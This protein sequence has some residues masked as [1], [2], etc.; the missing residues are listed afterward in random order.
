MP[1]ATLHGR[2]LTR[3]VTRLLARPGERAWRIIPGTP[4][5]TAEPPAYDARPQG[6]QLHLSATPASAPALLDRVVPVLYD[7][8]ARFAFAPTT[9]AVRRL[10]GP[11]C[12]RTDFGKVLSVHPHDEA[13]FSWLAHV[14]HA[15]TVRLAGPRILSAR[16]YRPGSLVHVAYGSFGTGADRFSVLDNDGLLRELLV[17]PDGSTVPE[18]RDGWDPPWAPCPL[19]PLAGADDSGNGRSGPPGEVRP[20]RLADRFVVRQTLRNLVTGAVHLASDEQAAEGHPT[21]V[22][23]KHAR[24]HSDV[25]PGGA[26]ARARLLHE[27][28]TLARLRGQVAVPHPL[29]V[30]AAGGDL[31]LVQE[32]LP[33]QPLRRWVRRRATGTAHAGPAAGTTVAMARRLVALVAAVHDSG[34]VLRDLDPAHL[35]VLPD[36]TPALIDV[37][38]AVERGTPASPRGTAGYLAPELEDA[39]QDLV[40][41]APAEDLYG[42]G[43][44][45]FLLATGND[46]V[47]PDDEPADDRPARDRLAAWLALVARYN[48]SARLL[49]P[50]IMSL[51]SDY[52]DERADLADVDRLLAA[53][54]ATAPTCLQVGLPSDDRLLADGLDHLAATMCPDDEHLWPPSA[55]GGR[56]D[57]RNVQHGASGVLAVLLRALAHGAS[58]DAHV[59]PVAIDAAARKAASWLSA[60]SDRGDR[61]LPGLYFGGAGVAWVLADAAAALGEPHLRTQ[62]ERLALRL[63]TRWPN[64]DVAHGIAGAALTQLYLSRVGTGHGGPGRFAGIRPWGTSAPWSGTGDER[65]LERAEAYG[66]QLLETAVPGPY[67]PTWSI[68]AGF[69]SRLAGARH[70]GFAHGVAGIG[71]T[72]LALGSALGEPAY[73]HLA[74]EAGYT[75]C[76]AARTDEDG[77]AWWPV[78]PEDG[79]RLPHWCSGSSG[80]GTFLL[81]LYAVTGEQRFGEYARAAAGAVHRA[82]WASPSSACHG[83]AGDGEFLLDAADVLADQTYRAWAEDLVPLLAVRHC[84]RGGRVLVPDETSRGVVADYNIGLAGVLGY[85][86]RL[87]YGGSRLFL[88]DDVLAEESASP[89]PGVAALW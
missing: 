19:G 44:L 69:P 62:A 15:A 70:Y 10:G 37:A 28:H 41:A 59:V 76:R 52:P 3:V 13:E 82:R 12:P 68:P 20:Q 32:R 75:L 42:L 46:P 30:F 49:G 40:E 51:M 24:A 26:D 79:V 72:L 78:G 84:H 80:V 65:F 27:A 4:W 48:D 66:R 45:L 57:P 47:L 67:G 14:L 50:A 39:G 25:D 61:I 7:H 23:V 53:D 18:N 81:R 43:A 55:Y 21:Q 33:G 87:R 77:A 71:Y 29:A 34:L 36:G 16:A 56:T 89:A 74:V 38:A 58:A 31:F 88:V 2:E 5:W 73:T 8:G 60:R 64:P 86:L 9:E 11:A 6:W 17:A 63:P 22:V 54:R 85:L 35:V 83:L 1:P